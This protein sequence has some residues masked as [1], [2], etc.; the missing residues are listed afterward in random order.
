MARRHVE[1]FVNVLIGCLIVAATTNAIA[2]ALLLWVHM[3]WRP[4][5]NAI[6]I[7][8]NDPWRMRGRV[9][10]AFY[11]AAGCWLASAG[12]LVELIVI[13]RSLE[14]YFGVKV[15]PDSIKYGI[16]S[17]FGGLAACSVIG[18]F[19]CLFA[20][21]DP[22][23]VW[24]QPRFRPSFDSPPQPTEHLAHNRRPVRC[25]YAVSVIAIALMF[26]IVVA[27][28]IVL[29]VM[30]K[31]VPKDEATVNN[32]WWGLLLIFGPPIAAIVLYAW[33]SSRIVARTPEEC[34]KKRDEHSEVKTLDF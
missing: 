7:L 2:G 31:D 32:L 1:F 33:L 6:Y 18:F 30:T 12:A 25:N 19:A 34:W 9:M 8:T 23:R 21:I 22:V 3:A 28:A 15:N 4:V 24:F 26:P 20:A 27:C 11:V 13:F 10:A 5:D 16:Y 29:A 17:M 14:V